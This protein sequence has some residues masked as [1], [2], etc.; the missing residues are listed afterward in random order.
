MAKEFDPLAVI[1]SPE[2][3]RDRIAKEEKLLER[4]RILLDLSERL[5]E[6]DKL[7]LPPKAEGK[8]T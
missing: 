4:L 2:A 7:K 3:I 8:P 5:Y 1:P 6:T